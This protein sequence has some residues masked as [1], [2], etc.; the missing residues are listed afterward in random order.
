MAKNGRI[1]TEMRIVIR[2]SSFHISK[3]IRRRSYDAGICRPSY[4]FFIA[5][6]CF[7]S[8]LIMTMLLAKKL[9]LDLHFKEINKTS[10]DKRNEDVSPVRCVQ[11]D[12][13][14]HHTEHAQYNCMAPQKT[15]G[16]D[17]VIKSLLPFMYGFNLHVLLIDIFHI[18]IISIQ[19][20]KINVFAQKIKVIVA[21]KLTKK[22]T[23]QEVLI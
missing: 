16:L 23:F 18:F 9:N 19:F 20:L 22:D 2:F 21:K 5:F 4:I 6:K 12:N 8:Y 3:V 13:V 10:N 7:C 1:S 17:G 14:D 15:R 11:I